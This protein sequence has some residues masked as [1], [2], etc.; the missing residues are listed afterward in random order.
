MQK[1][2]AVALVERLYTKP[3]QL[4]PTTHNA[5]GFSIYV[6]TAVLMLGVGGVGGAGGPHSV[7]VK[8][9]KCIPA[10]ASMI[11]QTGYI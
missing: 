1:V 10:I 8:K 7:R 3:H 2:T 5:G 9:K 6:F 11:G 4:S